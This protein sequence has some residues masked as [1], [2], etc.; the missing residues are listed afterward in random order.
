MRKK[1]NGKKIFIII[2]FV[3]V[4]LSALFFMFNKRRILSEPKGILMSPSEIRVSDAS[5]QMVVSWRD[6]SSNESGFSIKRTSDIVNSDFEEISKTNENI[7]NF[8]DTN[9]ESGQRYW[10]KVCAYNTDHTSNYSLV[11][12]VQSLENRNYLQNIGAFN[13]E[14][15]NLGIASGWEGN[16]N[17]SKDFVEYRV[18]RSSKNDSNSSQYFGLKG[19]IPATENY[20][21]ISTNEI[22]H[23]NNSSDYSI[24]TGDSL[25]LSLE[26]Y[27]MINHI[28][29]INYSIIVDFLN[30]NDE[31]ISNKS[32][33]LAPV[34]AEKPSIFSTALKDDF[35]VPVNANGLKISFLIKSTV[36]I[37]A[38]RSTGI[39][40]SDLRLNLKR[41]S[42]AQYEKI[43]VPADRDR[44]ILTQKI[45]FEPSEDDTY[46]NA[47]NYDVVAGKV[48]DY[49]RLLV[50]R[51]YNP[52]IKILG[53]R[54]FDLID[55]RESNFKD[56]EASDSPI[57]F[58]AALDRQKS[59]SQD[60]KWFYNFPSNVSVLKSY[61]DKRS[62][63]QNASMNKYD[64]DGVTPLPYVFYPTSQS[65]YPINFKSSSYK[66]AW[67]ENTIKTFYKYKFDGM[68]L[69]D[70]VSSTVEG[71]KTN[72][73]TGEQ[74]DVLLIDV[75]QD[76]VI[77]FSKDVISEVISQ[78]PNFNVVHNASSKY[79]DENSNIIN[80][81]FVIDNNSYDTHD[82][83][84]LIESIDKLNDANKKST[85]TKNKYIHETVKIYDEIDNSFY[86]A[87]QQSNDLNIY[88]IS[89]SRFSLASYLLSSNIYSAY[90]V[91]I[92]SKN[93][94]QNESVDLGFNF[95]SMIG[96]PDGDRM[97]NYQ[98][99][100]YN[101]D[102][103]NLNSDDK[104]MVQI[105]KYKNGIVLVNGSL[106]DTADITLEADYIDEFGR[107]FSKNSVIKLLP[108]TGR[109]LMNPPKTS[110]NIEGDLIP[111]NGVY[112]QPLKINLRSEELN[113]K[114]VDKIFY[115]IDDGLEQKYQTKFELKNGV[116]KLK[117]YSVSDENVYGA[118]ENKIFIINSGL[119]DVPKIYSLKEVT[120][121][122]NISLDVTTGDNVEKVVLNNSNQFCIVVN[123]SCSIKADLSLGKNSFSL[124]SVDSN[125]NESATT[126]INI[127]RNKLGDTNGDNVI[128]SQ[129]LSFMM[130]NWG[131]GKNY[132]ADFN[133]DGRSD[134][135]DFSIFTANWGK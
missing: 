1:R 9:V 106:T 121:N 133:G 86:S 94:E 93:S 63:Y 61:G 128:D 41:S 62:S 52:N 79:F 116:H 64:N 27:Y 57:P 34:S 130:S 118:I 23:I 11:G 15:N 74:N 85:E 92:V 104:K 66:I 117:Y 21:S 51:Y 46:E 126:S 60:E 53:H 29:G 122:S 113:G 14:S 17:L 56:P 32:F 4:I 18:Q 16:S 49:N 78:I 28:E 25:S 6:N 112:N 70:I 77:Q 89:W 8:I 58:G 50:L 81:E 107:S 59:L 98:S 119:L 76:L 45:N 13:S 129:D 91:E 83:L 40:I 102:D 54:T 31:V 5:G 24:H 37:E 134:I 123:S 39:Y 127:T 131:V 114:I 7:T 19:P 110:L 99:K 43:L 68:F 10:Y 26:K 97:I 96:Q 71:T 48:S 73:S 125:G 38:G 84:S 90:G 12:T 87:V 111:V 75:D 44:E 65:K 69:D 33:S 100:I 80:R 109:I 105:K 35:V 47:L 42:E 30:V 115:Q 82:W 3:V 2:I 101:A 55:D 22:A 132:L 120:F 103:S 88:N 95:S 72:P 20:V 36:S 135:K 108:H 67:V 124:K